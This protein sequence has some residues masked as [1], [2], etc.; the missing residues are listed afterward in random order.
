[1]KKSVNTLIVRSIAL[2]LHP[3][4]FYRIVFH[5]SHGSCKHRVVQFDT[6]LD[7]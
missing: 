2:F 4:G 1:M 3:F 6:N 7:E 5:G